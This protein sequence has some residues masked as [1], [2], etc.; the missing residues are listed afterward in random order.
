MVQGI[1]GLKTARPVEEDMDMAHAP[2]KQATFP[3][4]VKKA[5]LWLVTD[6]QLFV[7]SGVIMQVKSTV[8]SC[9]PPTSL[10][11]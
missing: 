7:V 10:D 1:L 5:A 4:L 2:G 11:L 6:K 8:D 3:D 9:A